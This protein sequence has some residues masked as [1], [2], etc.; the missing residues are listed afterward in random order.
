MAL[1]KETIAAAYREWA[2]LR[3]AYEQRPGP[4]SRAI[5]RKLGLPGCAAGEIYKTILAGWPGVAREAPAAVP[6]VPAAVP[7]AVLAIVASDPWA[8]KDAAAAIVRGQLVYSYSLT[9]VAEVWGLSEPTM[10]MVQAVAGIPA[11]ALAVAQAREQASAARQAAERKARK[12]AAGKAAADAV[13][14]SLTDADYG[15]VSVHAADE[16]GFLGASGGYDYTRRV[17]NSAAASRIDAAY[18]A[19]YDAAN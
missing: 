17:P 7:A 12:E 15:M 19:A 14:A 18:K 11:V 6:A 10:D 4:E 3:D 16:D 13:R 2:G 8:A 5:A 9:R 1:S